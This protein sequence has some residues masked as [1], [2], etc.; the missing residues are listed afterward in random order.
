MEILPT[1]SH[2]PLAGGEVPIRERVHNN[3]LSIQQTQAGLQ[4][5]LA[6]NDSPSHIESLLQQ[7]QSPIQ[8]LVQISIQHPPV[9]SQNEIDVVSAIQSQFQTMQTDLH[10][11]SP[12]ALA[13]L[14]GNSSTLDQMFATEVAG[15]PEPNVS[16]LQAQNHLSALSDALHLHIK[17][18]GVYSEKTDAIVNSMQHPMAELNNLS[19]SGVLTSAQSGVVIAL[20][21]MY[22]TTIQVPGMATPETIKQ[23]D[24][25]LRTLNQLLTSG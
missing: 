1:S 24:T 5:A 6:S 16:A 20:T 8:D 9:L 10:A 7:L 12:S 23:F 3:L 18:H 2:G 17:A 21:T 19:D 4:I 22:S 15:L 13:A 14:Q 11:I 25:Q